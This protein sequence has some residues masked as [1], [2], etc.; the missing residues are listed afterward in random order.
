MHAIRAAHAFDG[1][2]FLRGGPTV[3]VDGDR[4]AGLEP[5]HAAPPPLAELFPG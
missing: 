4:I 3:L 1:T 5:G 2:R